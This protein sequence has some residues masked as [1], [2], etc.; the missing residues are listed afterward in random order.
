MDK[1]GLGRLL[2]STQEVLLDHLH[3]L[4]SE[5]TPQHAGH[6]TGMFSTMTSPQLMA[7]LGDRALLNDRIQA[8][9][10]ALDRNCS[11]PD[12]TAPAAVD[13]RIPCEDVSS[14]E[15][16]SNE[17]F[18]A[19]AQLDTQ[20]SAQITGMLLELDPE[21]VLGLLQC[22]ASLASAV[23]SARRE[24]LRATKQRSP[25]Q[26]Q[27]EPS[28]EPFEESTLHPPH[29]SPVRAYHTPRLQPPYEPPVD[30]NAEDIGEAL[31]ASV[32]DIYPRN[33]AKITGMFMELGPEK[34]KTLF[35]RHCPGAIEEL[36]SDCQDA[37]VETGQWIPEEIRM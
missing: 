19:V 20:L 9:L 6:V 2:P 17:L 8:A 10:T 25:G 12:N 23:D 35:G 22:P 37:L 30:P 32:R 1:P 3:S 34:L 33:A 36:L 24:Y 16:L 28:D 29:G 11:S 31:F 14:K 13:R 18:L 26:P 5:V 4:V 27:R 7:V 15:E 21:T